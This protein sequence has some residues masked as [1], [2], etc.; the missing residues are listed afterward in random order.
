MYPQKSQIAENVIDM[1]AQW[2]YKNARDYT[3]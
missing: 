2:G 1:T 3:I